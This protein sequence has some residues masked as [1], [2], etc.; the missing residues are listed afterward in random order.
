[1][2]ILLSIFLLLGIANSPFSI[3]H[4]PLSIMNCELSIVNSEF[5]PL[6]APEPWR[7][8]FV[9]S[10]PR[11]KLCIDLYEESVNVPGMDLF[12][13]MNGYLAG[14]DV[15]GTWMV[16]SYKVIDHSHASVRLSNDLGSE[17]QAAELTLS[18]DTALVFRMVGSCVMKQRDGKR[19]IKL[20]Q[21]L[22]F[23]RESNN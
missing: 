7:G 1:M 3:V 19:L 8:T 20:P 6:S 2:R 14:T 18:G 21:E 13:P 22:N 11:A 16:T 15:Y 23:R 9:S 5:P 4:S 12:G 10:S 17:T